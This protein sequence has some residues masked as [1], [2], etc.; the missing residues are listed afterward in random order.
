MQSPYS[1]VLSLRY[2]NEGNSNKGRNC[3]LNA[4]HGKIGAA[5]FFAVN[6]E[7]APGF[8]PEPN[9]RLADILANIQLKRWRSGLPIAA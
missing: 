5:P 3:E 6:D 4:V 7:L 2:S 9:Q 1:R 8:S